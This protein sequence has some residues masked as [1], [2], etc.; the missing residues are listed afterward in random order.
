MDAV[1][2]VCKV[3]VAILIRRPAI[4]CVL[5]LFYVFGALF[6]FT[7]APATRGLFFA[8]VAAIPAAGLLAIASERLVPYAASAGELGVPRHAATL[9]T[10]Q[11]VLLLLVAGAPWA[12]AVT[13]DGPWLRVAALLLGAAAL[14]TLLVGGGLVVGSL[15]LAA[16]C[17]N[18]TF[19]PPEYWLAWPAVPYVALI[20]S[21]VAFYRWLRFL[22]RVELAAPTLQTAYSDAAHEESEIAAVGNADRVRIA[23]AELQQDTYISDAVGWLTDGRLSP[24]G[25][26][27]GLGF[28]S[29]TSWRTVAIGIGIGLLA[30]LAARQHYLLRQPHTIYAL[31]CVVTAFLSLSRVSAIAQRWKRTSVEQEL[32]QLTPLW[33]SALMLK[34]VFLKSMCRVQLGPVTGWIVISTTLVVLG[35][36][37]FREVAYGGLYVTAAF[38][39]ACSYLWVALASREVKEWQ[40]SS[41]VAAL[42]AISG[43]VTV[44]FGDPLE[45]YYRALGVA[46][47]L[48][49]PVLSFAIF[50]FRP[51]QFPARPRSN[52]PQL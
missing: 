33:P 4:P 7:M 38:L 43:V 37:D 26:G 21:F 47:I 29:G 19:G 16:W 41:I 34:S 46:A 24:A 42:L 6:I 20:G 8:V 31:T 12:V 18:A 11:V 15:I 25:L 28:W 5:S 14:G 17:I 1:K 3:L 48:V 2:R 51:L 10:V 22:A 30:V 45:I 40:V 36:V 44:Q 49:P 23:E 32:L 50:Q 39:V 13:Y 9:R 27:V 35:C 52:K